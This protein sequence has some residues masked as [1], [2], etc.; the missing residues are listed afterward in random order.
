MLLIKGTMLSGLCWI[1]QP[2]QS[3]SFAGGWEQDAVKVSKNIST[4][5]G[6]VALCCFP[7][8]ALLARALLCHGARRWPKMS[9]Y[10]LMKTDEISLLCAPMSCLSTAA[11][12]NI[13]FSLPL[14]ILQWKPFQMRFCWKFSMNGVTTLRNS[15]ITSAVYFSITSSF[16]K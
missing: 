11:T 15:A 7:R 6:Y 10:F 16:R 1:I 2:F 12:N 3:K 9:P 8:Q 14:D 4:H 5:L 13:L